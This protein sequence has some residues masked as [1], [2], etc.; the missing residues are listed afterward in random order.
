MKWSSAL[1]AA[2]CG[3]VAAHGDLPIPK[4]VGGRKLLADMRARRIP[5]LPRPQPVQHVHVERRSKS[6]K[7]QANTSGQ[8]GKGYGSCA[9]GYCCSS[10][11]YFCPFSLTLS[12]TTSNI[13][14]DGVER[15]Q[16][17]AP[18]PTARSTMVLIATG[19][20]CDARLSPRVHVFTD[21]VICTEQEAFR[22]GHIL[23]PTAE[24]GQCAHQWCRHLRLCQR[25]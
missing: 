2:S 6:E 23:G 19:Y 21:V 13:R 4:I 5:D 14:V 17:T 20:A 10:E 9:V 24:T 15:V 16:I 1:I 22:T 11:G 12:R 18:R 3:L 7:R 8:C 25:R